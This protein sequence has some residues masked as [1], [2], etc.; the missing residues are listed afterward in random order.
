MSTTTPNLN[1]FKYDTTSATDLASA[2][3]INTA[4]NNN[5]DALDEKCVTVASKGTAYGGTQQPVYVNSAGQIATCD[6][7]SE[8]PAG[9]TAEVSLSEN[10]YI[11]FSNDFVILFSKASINQNIASSQ[12][13]DVV[14]IYPISINSPIVFSLGNQPACYTAIA[15]ITNT[16]CTFRFR[17][18]TSSTYTLTYAN[19]IAIGS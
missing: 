7:Y 14:W 13:F 5:W 18:T 12:H 11:K 9:L 19:H 8:I 17:N 3:N 2:F 16:D 10:G 6:A 1:L 4:L 15:N